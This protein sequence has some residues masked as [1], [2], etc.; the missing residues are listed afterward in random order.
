[1]IVLGDT[2][3]DAEVVHKAC[4]DRNYTWIVPANPERVYE[5][6]KGNRPKLRSRLK[7]WTSLSL[8]TIRLHASTG[9]YAGYRRLSKWR[10]GP[11]Q[12]PR[13][14]YASQEKSEVR[15]VGCVQLIF[16]TMKPDLKT[17]TPDDVKILMTNDT[18][19]SVSEVIELYSLRWQVELFFKELK[20][21]LG[22]SQYSF[23]CFESVKAWVETAITTVLFLEH[24]R[25]KHLQD[26]RL[27]LE[28][29]Q[30]WQ[31]QR[32]HGMCSAFRQECERRELKYLSDRLKT[33]GGIQKLKRADIAQFQELPD[34][35]RELAMTIYNALR[36]ADILFE[37]VLQ[38]EGVD[39]IRP[40]VPMFKTTDPQAQELYRIAE[41]NLGEY[42]GHYNE[43]MA[44]IQRT[45]AQA[46]VFMTTL[47]NLRVKMLG[48]R[49]IGKNPSLSS[50]E[51]LSV[52][53]EARAQL[54]AIDRALDE[55]DLSHYPKTIAV[56]PSRT[57]EQDFDQALSTTDNTPESDAVREI[58]GMH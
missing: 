46:T 4:D 27:S 36:R 24:Q 48:Y 28:K 57:L 16:S 5:G 49:L 50:E 35:V 12:K 53:A 56:I 40:G 45:E 21:T 20:S 37:E 58:E 22:F 52:L 23:Q 18:R 51:F 29:R 54:S 34:T 31:A 2:A 39:R 17:A 13:V 30:W 38:S 3:Y 1:M 14:F 43:L 33:S 11:K 26:R 7:D 55:L 15:S 9:K 19:L 8:K 6:S 41:R 44:G 42:R 25:A 10:V 47:D 32:L